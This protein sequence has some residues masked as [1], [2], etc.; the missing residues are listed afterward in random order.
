M[1]KPIV[2]ETSAEGRERARRETEQSRPRRE[3]A[4]ATAHTAANAF[5]TGVAIAGKIHPGFAIASGAIGAV[6]GYEKTGSLKGAALGTVTGGNVPQSMVDAKRNSN[7]AFGAQ[8]QKQTNV[9]NNLSRDAIVKGLG[10]TVVGTITGDKG[11]AQAGKTML[12]AGAVVRATS[13]ARNTP[14]AK[15]K[16]AA[17]EGL[18]ARANGGSAALGM[19]GVA[20]PGHAAGTEAKKAGA[21]IKISG[22]A[23]NEGI[24]QGLGSKP[25]ASEPK[26]GLFA[27]VAKGIKE[28]FGGAPKGAASGPNA[29]EAKGNTLKSSDATGKGSYK[30]LDGRSVEGTKAQQAAW[31]KR[32]TSA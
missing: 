21:N 4:K 5:V 12:A 7:S 2:I 10:E 1:V 8:K 19:R 9:L 3:V 29:A 14:A 32:R 16:T 30:T 22:K 27:G 24:K 13:A 18:I 26:A 28:K 11:R 17:Q 23:L 25:Q 31:S 6:V 15:T 20:A